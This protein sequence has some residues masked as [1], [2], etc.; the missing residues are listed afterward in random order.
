MALHNDLLDQAAHLA[1]REPRRPRQASLRRAVSAAYYALFHLLTGEAASLITP[2]ALKGFEPSV[3]RILAHSEM[4]N[5]CKS[6]SQAQVPA[7]LRSHAAALGQAD[8][9]DVAKAF[10]QLQE[11]RHRAD[12]DLATQHS[13]SEALRLIRVAQD[14]FAKWERI[15]R[16]DGARAFLLALA[17]PG[18]LKPR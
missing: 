10:V 9:R 12:Y 1:R 17:L 3:R 13:R 8:L 7:P 14:A 6:V 2:T 11:A 5:F 4:K 16:T 15:R 18:L